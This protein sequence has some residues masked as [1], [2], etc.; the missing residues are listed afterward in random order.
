MHEAK[1]SAEPKGAGFLNNLAGKMVEAAPGWQK[2]DKVY[3]PLILAVGVLLVLPCSTR[4]A[5][6]YKLLD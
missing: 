3:V 4:P 2:E 6:S 1:K 5:A